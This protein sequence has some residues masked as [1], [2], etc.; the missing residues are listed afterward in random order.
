M[1]YYTIFILF[2]PLH[3]FSFVWLSCSLYELLQFIWLYVPHS[4]QFFWQY[5]GF[6]SIEVPFKEALLF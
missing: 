4:T 3:S 1:F 5:E 6:R 2:C